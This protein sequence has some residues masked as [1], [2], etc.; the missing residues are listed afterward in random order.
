[1]TE[2][3]LNLTSTRRLSSDLQWVESYCDSKVNDM[4]HTK[5]LI[6]Y[7]DDVQI[8]NYFL[9]LRITGCASHLKCSFLFHFVLIWL[10]KTEDYKTKVLLTL[11]TAIESTLKRVLWYKLWFSVA[12]VCGVIWK[13]RLTKCIRREFSILSSFFLVC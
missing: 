10:S 7:G 3:V 9:S 12:N 8:I 4:L 11:K 6:S 13:I 5:I 2:R 1:M